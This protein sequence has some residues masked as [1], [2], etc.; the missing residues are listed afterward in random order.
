MTAFTQTFEP[1]CT[2]PKGPR[3]E[4]TIRPS[5]V[6][7]TTIPPQK[8]PACVTIAPFVMLPAYSGRMTS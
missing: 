2:T 7:S 6:K 1:S 3:I 4:V 5:A 8:I